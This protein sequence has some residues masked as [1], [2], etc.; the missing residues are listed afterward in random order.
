MQTLEQIIARWDSG[1]GK[2]FKRKLI[3]WA[4]YGGDGALPPDDIGCMCAQGKVLHLLG[5]WSPRRLRDAAQ[6][7]ADAETAKLLGISRAHA[8]LLRAINDSVDGAPSVVLTHPERVIGD[9]A[10]TIL[11]FWHHLD[12]MSAEDWDKV[13][14]AGDAAQVAAGDV[15]RVVAR[16]AAGVAAGVAAGDA[17]GD[18]AQ[19]AAGATHEIQGAS[20]MLELGQPFFFLPMFGFAAPEDITKDA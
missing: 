1:E 8:V 7:A 2:P 6:S 16:E 10:P 15:A 9:Q 18:V 12:A 11:A 19:V 13:V 20:I 17:A 3:D 4:K 14:V 5:G